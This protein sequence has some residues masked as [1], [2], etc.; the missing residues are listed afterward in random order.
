MAPLIYSLAFLPWG[1]PFLSRRAPS[2]PRG[3]P[4][5]PRGIPSLPRGIPSLP[6]GIRTALR[7][8]APNAPPPCHRAASN[9]IYS[10]LSYV[11]QRYRTLYTGYDNNAR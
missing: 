4:S 7:T 10:T 8:W 5:V 2:L 9:V 3:I 1:I 6:R 11:I